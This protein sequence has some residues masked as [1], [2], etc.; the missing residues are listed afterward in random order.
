MDPDERVLAGGDRSATVD[1]DPRVDLGRAGVH[2]VGA[3]S[4]DVVSKAA[5]R[6]EGGF[7][8]VGGPPGTGSCQDVTAGDIVAFDADE[9]D[10]HA[11]HGARTVVDGAMALERTD[12]RAMVRRQQDD[13]VADREAV[14][15]EGAG[16]HGARALDREDPVDVE[17]RPGRVGGRDTTE[18]VVERRP[19][20]VDAV[21]GRCGHRDDRCVGQRRA[22]EPVAHLLGG[23]R[24]GLLVDEVALG[25]RHDRGTGAQDVE[26]LQMLLRLGLPSFVG[27]HHEQHRPNRTDARQHVADEPFMARN[28]H[29]GD[30]AAARQRAPRVPEVDRE[31]PAL[32]LVPAVRVHTGEGDDQGGFA[33]VDVPGGRDDP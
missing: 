30:L 33:V 2:L 17:P 4:T 22:G 27:G 11:G 1:T 15:G 20:F 21:P 31:P 14:A 5:H 18:H 24:R 9:V 7:E 12:A 19:E 13:V 16:H 28:I 32:L 10:G 3:T 23:D 26:D 29:E 25:Q 8:S 6:S